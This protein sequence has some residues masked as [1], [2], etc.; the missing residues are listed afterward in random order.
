MSKRNFW[1]KYKQ[2]LEAKGKKC[3]VAQAKTIEYLVED[4]LESEDNPGKCA[5]LSSDYVL[6]ISPETHHPHISP[7]T[8]IVIFEEEKGH[9]G[10]NIFTYSSDDNR[11]TLLSYKKVD[12]TQLVQTIEE[13]EKDLKKTTNQIAGLLTGFNLS[14]SEAL[15]SGVRYTFKKPRTRR[16]YIAFTV[17]FQKTGS[18][19]YSVGFTNEGHIQS[20]SALIDEDSIPN[21]SVAQK[22][23]LGLQTVPQKTRDNIIKAVRKA[24]FSVLVR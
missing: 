4:S 21:F 14:Q 18:L 1:K 3:Q 5:V 16:K 22:L 11:R 20:V 24:P 10:L 7:F 15:I 12:P 8:K 17:G 9:L 13:I 2:E 23:A 6:A 19:E